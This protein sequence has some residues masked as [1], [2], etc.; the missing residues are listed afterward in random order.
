MTN[1]LQALLEVKPAAEITETVA[2]KRLGTEFTIKALTGVDIDAI[3]AQATRPVK[4][5]KKVEQKVD[6]HEAARL[7]VAKAVVEPNFADAALLQHF[8]ATDASECVQKALLAGEIATLQQAIFELSG[9][10]DLDEEIEDA[11]N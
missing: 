8:G 2:I 7:L 10:G 11:K 6:E 1:A 9:F 5:G 4:T 3:Q